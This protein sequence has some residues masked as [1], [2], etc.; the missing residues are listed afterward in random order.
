LCNFEIFFRFLN[1]NLWFF[2]HIFLIFSIFFIFY[3]SLTC[4]LL[5]LFLIF[6]ILVKLLLQFLHFKSYIN[7]SIAYLNLSWLLKKKAVYFGVMRFIIKQL[8]T[9][10]LVYC[11]LIDTLDIL[12]IIG[13]CV[14]WKILLFFVNLIKIILSIECLEYFLVFINVVHGLYHF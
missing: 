7:Q 1:S 12:H 13:C 10:L 3:Y 8:L 5:N 9:I 2:W 6:A 14:F 11:Y 4:L